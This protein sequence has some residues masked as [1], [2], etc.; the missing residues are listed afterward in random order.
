MPGVQ[1]AVA[2]G[3]NVVPIR[4]PPAPRGIG[5][6]VVQEWDAFWRSEYALAVKWRRDGRAISRL[7]ELYDLHDRFLRA[8]RK[9][10]LVPGSQ[11]QPIANPLTRQLGAVDAEIRQLEDRFG[12]STRAAMTLGV[13]F[14]DLQKTL[15]ELNKDANDGD[16][17]TQEDPRLKASR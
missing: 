12:L 9:R 2:R 15:D 8:T 10:P 4:V 14:T 5:K 3:A 6:P 7:F 1:I 17:G 13:V 11:G 16:S